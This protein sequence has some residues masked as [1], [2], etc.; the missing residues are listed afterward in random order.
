VVTS[1][2]AYPKAY[3]FFEE[4]IAIVAEGDEIIRRITLAL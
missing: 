2:A 3:Y 4:N 1:H